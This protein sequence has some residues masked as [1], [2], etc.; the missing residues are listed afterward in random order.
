MQN[1]ESF[2]NLEVSFPFSLAYNKII[3]YKTTLEYI[4]SKRSNNMMG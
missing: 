1:K 4:I 3:E 2:L